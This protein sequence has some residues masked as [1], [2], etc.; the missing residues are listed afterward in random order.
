MSTVVKDVKNRPR[1]CLRGDFQ[2][3]G[4]GSVKVLR[5]NKE[6]CVGV[7]W[8]GEVTGVKFKE[9]RQSGARVPIVHALT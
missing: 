1:G 9:V 2:A 8:L 7:E 3:E 6:Q 5:N 4:T